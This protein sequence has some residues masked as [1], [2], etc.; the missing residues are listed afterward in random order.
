MAQ[1]QQRLVRLGPFVRPDRHR[2][3][4]NWN[5]CLMKVTI[6]GSSWVAGVAG[7]AATAVVVVGFAEAGA[8]V[9][10]D[11]L[12]LSDS[13]S[14]VDGLSAAP[15]TM[16]DLTPSLVAAEPGVG[17]AWRGPL[18]PERSTELLPRL[19]D[20]RSLEPSRSASAVCATPTGRAMASAAAD[21]YT[22]ARLPNL[23]MIIDFLSAS[24]REISSLVISM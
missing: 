11:V 10:V 8:E 16:L 19:F 20:P 23:C 21:A 12:V 4:K 14:V 7:F 1:G 6:G 5:I 17:A 13:L 3:P 9:E 18:G 15:E 2:K 22:P 24:Y